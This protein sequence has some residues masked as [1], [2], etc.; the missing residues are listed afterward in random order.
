M[1]V[2]SILIILT[3]LA[4]LYTIFKK[5]RYVS[6]LPRVCFP[7][8]PFSTILR[9]TT[10]IDIFVELVNLV[11]AEAMWVHF[12]TVTVHPSQLWISGYLWAHDMNIIKICC[13]CQLQI[14]WQNNVLMDLDR[15]VVK[16]PALGKISIWAIN[17]LENIQMNMPY[18]IKVFGKSWT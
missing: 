13:F 14:D 7:L 12:A 16:L 4:I 18:Q 17:N 6:A 1:W 2:S 11:M 10:H 8:Y 15:N 3:I 9:G 5:C